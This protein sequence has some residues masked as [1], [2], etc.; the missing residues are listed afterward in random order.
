MSVVDAAGK[1]RAVAITHIHIAPLHGNHCHFLLSCG[2]LLWKRWS[3]SKH[4]ERKKV[5]W[6]N[7]DFVKFAFLILLYFII[8]LFIWRAKT[9][10]HISFPELRKSVQASFLQYCWD[11]SSPSRITTW[12]SSVGEITFNLFLE[13]R[14]KWVRL[15]R[16]EVSDPFISSANRLACDMDFVSHFLHDRQVKW[17]RV[18]IPWFG[19]THNGKHLRNNSN[20]V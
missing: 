2:C 19:N 17:Y 12:F 5:R 14:I 16:V 7:K 9:S 11:F 10:S 13:V 6:I 18:Q 4:I 1:R 20:V 3:R 15:V 8:T